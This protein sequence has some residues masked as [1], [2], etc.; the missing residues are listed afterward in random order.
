MADADDVR[1]LA[2]VQRRNMHEGNVDLQLK[3]KQ[4]VEKILNKPVENL[5]D[6]LYDGSLLCKII[7]HFYPG[8]I[9]KFFEAAPGSTLRV[10]YIYDNCAQFFR[11]ARELGVPESLFFEPSQLFG[12]QD[13]MRVLYCVEATGQILDPA[14]FSRRARAWVTPPMSSIKRPATLTPSTPYQGSAMST[15]LSSGK[16]RPDRVQQYDL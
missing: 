1:P 9:L 4:W 14:T 16:F 3:I 11:A 2:L 13:M 8:S 5:F 12:R 15:P 7:N 6:A 10:Q